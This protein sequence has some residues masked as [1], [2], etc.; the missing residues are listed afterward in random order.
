MLRDWLASP[1]VDDIMFFGDSEVGL[2]V[3]RD[4]VA[5]GKKP[6]LELAGYDC[7]VVW[8][9][10]DLDAATEAL[11]ECFYGSGQICMVPE[12]TL[13][14]PEIADALL[15]RLVA[16]ARRSPRLSRRTRRDPQPGAEDRQVLRLPRGGQVRGRRGADRRSPGARQAGRR[17]AVRRTHDRPVLHR[18]GQCRPAEG[19]RLPHRVRARARDPWRH[20]PH[21][22]TVRR[23]Q[24]PDPQD[25]SPPG[26]QHRAS[27]GS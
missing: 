8:R 21:R 9:D 6:V 12:W 5:R 15:G 23:A 2:E 26:D 1:L 4:C 3:G 7:C 14:H 18:R 17:R 22:R 20:R 13:V 19:E 16:A 11:C 24:L 25:V 27:Q 10:A